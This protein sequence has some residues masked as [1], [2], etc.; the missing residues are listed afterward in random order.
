MAD[1]PQKVIVQASRIDDSMLPPIF[2]L[3]YRLY[4]IQ[5]SGDLKNVADASNNASDLAYQA[6]VKNQEQDVILADHAVRITFAKSQLENHEGRITNAESAIVSLGSRVSTAE[7]DIDFIQSDYVS[8]SEAA[9]QALSGPLS[10]SGSYS[11]NG[12]QVVGSRVVGFT[13]ATGSSYKGSFN[14]DVS[15]PVSATYQQSE[16]Q[17]ISSNLTAALR[18]MKAYE[19]ALRLHGLID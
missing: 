18:R 7:S 8:K 4:V 19:D 12:T 16:L 13:A 17:R 5:Q 6:A 3:A 14:S 15:L 9:A 1:E 11:V 2:S 10:V